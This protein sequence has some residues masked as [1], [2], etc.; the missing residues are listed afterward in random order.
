VVNANQV[1]VPIL[2]QVHFI[3]PMDVLVLL[4]LNVQAITVTLEPAQTIDQVDHPLVHHPQVTTDAVETLAH[5]ITT[6]TV[7]IALAVTALVEVT[8]LI[9]VVDLVHQAVVVQ[10]HIALHPSQ[11]STGLLGLL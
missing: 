8:D 11:E 7:I 2:A 10:V 1:P 5:Q 6:V 9:E 3:E 4:V